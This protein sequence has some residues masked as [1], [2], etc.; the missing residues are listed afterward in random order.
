[1]R[2]AIGG[3]ARQGSFSSEA[4]APLHDLNWRFLDLLASPP[5]G[6]RGRCD[7]DGT[8]RASRWVAPMSAAERAAAAQ[9]PYA[10]FDLRFEDE[11]YWRVR[12]GTAGQWRIADQPAG[13]EPAKD[14]AGFVRLALFYAWHVSS[15]SRNTAR[16]LLG[17]SENTAGAFR[18]AALASL[19]ALAAGETAN[20]GARFW[21]CG[22][23]WN[24]LIGAAA[25]N[26]ERGLRRIQLFGL[27]LAA[28]SLLV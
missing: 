7:P 25:R 1:M 2:D 9:C 26:D 27:Q 5:G 3:W 20:L 23:Y 12:L 17:M 10:L 13:E 8:E 11:S 18:S 22:A 15:T 4:L 21:N 28:A 14:M 6:W 24:A 16:L 19:T